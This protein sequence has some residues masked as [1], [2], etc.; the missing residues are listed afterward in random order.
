MEGAASLGS[1]EEVVLAGLDSGG[2]GGS[3]R[4]VG[5]GGVLK[6]DC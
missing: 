6:L 5:C 3:T 2:V 1:T 4:R